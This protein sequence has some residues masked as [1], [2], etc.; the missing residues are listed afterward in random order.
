MLHGAAG[1]VFVV[2]VSQA[3]CECVTRLGRVLPV[4][5]SYL[6]ELG[7]AARH[8]PPTLGVFVCDERQGPQ[9][10]E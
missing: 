7:V 6:A 10:R 2:F 9:R 3:E 8:C 4:C 1:R 5:P